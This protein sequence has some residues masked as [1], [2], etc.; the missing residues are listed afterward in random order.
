MKLR[1]NAILTASA[2]STVLLLAGCSGSSDSGGGASGDSTTI[3]GKVT[4]SGVASGKL[5][6]KLQAMA[7]APKGKPGSKLYK[8]Q[9]FKS[10]SSGDGNVEGR[11]LPAREAGVALS[12]A[13]VYL[14]DA[15]HPEWLH[16]VAETT[17]DA[18]GNF[19]LSEM[20]NAA[21][22][23]GATYADGDPIPAG[24]YTLMAVEFNPV[25]LKIETVA[26]QS[27][28]EDFSGNVSGADLVAQESEAAPKVQTMFGVAKNTDGTQTWGD[29][30]VELA[31]NAAVQI[32][33]SMAMHRL[34]VESFIEITPTPPAGKW[35]I[36]PDWLSATYYLDSGA[37]WTTGSTYTITV[38]GKD[39]PNGEDN[40][41]LNVYGKPLQLSA[42]GTFT[43][44]A[45]GADTQSPT[46]QLTSPTLAQT[47]NPIELT[48]PIR[49]GANELMDVNNLLL[50]ATPSLGAKPGVIYLGK[51]SD[52]LYEYEF[53]LGEPLK[54]NTTYDLTVSGGKDLA[55]NVM[56][57]LAISFTTEAT[58]EG[59]TVI[60]ANST[61]EEIAKA[62]AQAEVK[63]VFAKWIRAMNERNL[64][65]MQNVML[66]DFKLEYD[67]AANGFERNDVNRDG[68]YDL[69]EFSDMLSEA[70]TFWDYCSTTITGSIPSE[71][72][73]VGDLADFEFKLD[74]SS[75]NTSQDCAEATPEESLF[76]QLQKVNGGWYMLRASEGID[77][78]DQ[79]IV[80][81]DVLT[82]TAPD[83]AAVLNFYDE[84]TQ[85]DV[86]HP[87]EWN[88]VS[89]AASYVMIFV[90]ARDPESGF[91]MV[92]PPTMTT[93]DI[94]PSQ[95]LESNSADVS[96]E[97]GFHREFEPRPGSE[98]YWQ[99]AALGSNSVRDVQEGRNTAL[100]RDII[101]IS[102]LRR[103]KI[104][105]EY[106]ELD[107]QVAPTGGA[108]VT[109]SEFI[110]GY[111]LGSAGQADITIITERT[112]VTQGMVRVS[113]NTYS[114]YPV[115]LTA[116]TAADGTAIM[117]GTVTVQLNQGR[118]WVEIMDEYIDW[119]TCVDEP[120][121]DALSQQEREALRKGFQILTTGGIA[122]VINVGSVTAIA[123]NG[124]SV[125][126]T[127]DGWDYYE[128]DDVVEITVSGTVDTS[129]I[130]G[131]T[132]D[133]L[134]L[135]VWNHDLQANVYRQVPVSAGSFS[136]TVK[137][138]A[139]D[140]WINLHYCDCNNGGGQGY[141]AHFG[142]KTNTGSVYVPPIGN[143]TVTGVG[144]DADNDGVDDTLVQ[145]ENWGNGGNWRAT[146]VTS[147]TVIVRGTLLFGK[148]PSGQNQARYDAGSEGGW[149]SEPL[150]VDASGNFEIAIEL[151]NGW[152]YVNINDVKGNWYN[153]NIYT[154]GG[155]PVIRPTITAINGAA[156]AGGD[157]ETAQCDVTISGTALE[158]EV[159]LFWNGNAEDT[160][161]GYQ[162]FWEEILTEAT[163][164]DANGNYTFSATLPVV[165][166]SSYSYA[167][168]FIDVFDAN[169]NWTGVRVTVAAGTD[170]AYI[171][172]VME[173]TD[174]Q[175]AGATSL[176]LQNSWGDG[177]EYT[178]ALDDY[179]NIATDSVTIL[180]TTTQPGRTIKAEVHT[181]GVRVPYSI[182]AST[183]A[184][185]SG[186]YDWSLSGVLVYEGHNNISVSDGKNWY[187]VNLNATNANVLPTPPIAIT[188]VT[189]Y[190]GVDGTGGAIAVTDNTPANS[191]G[192]MDLAAGSAQ[193]I[194]IEGTTTAPD[195][196]GEYHMDGFGGRYQITGGAF[197]MTVNL[198]DGYNGVGINDTEWNNFHINVFTT[199]GVIRPQYLDITSH[200][201]GQTGLSGAVTISGSIDSDAD[202][203][204][205]TTDFEPNYVGA[206]VNDCDPTTGEC[207]WVEYSS[208][209]GAS[210]WGAQP[211]TLTDN[212]NGTYSFSFDATLSGG[213]AEVNVWTDGNMA[214]GAWASHGENITL[215]D[216]GCPDCTWYWKAGKQAQSSEIS[217]ELHDRIRT[218]RARMK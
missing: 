50:K 31:S 112:G 191:C 132:I 44:S 200:T 161:N 217:A 52:N 144:L 45:T 97:F 53:V 139:G 38:H 39:S 153:V 164:P 141:E 142:V 78:R 91:A 198:Y 140:N 47:A 74:G 113:G 170:C 80:A 100:P 146:A 107:T 106:L 59:V 195:G 30:A 63:D 90:D 137:V 94:P 204:T 40:A 89:D 122:P 67:V 3:S 147:N 2:L 87:F 101:A 165:G 73:I 70:F 57:S 212:G 145:K 16:P 36:S 193:S 126:L 79:T 29:A 24:N 155:K 102:E 12:N 186:T 185:G 206:F 148:D 95:E 136:T 210:E 42:V 9:Q 130:G 118:N 159:R 202:A 181:C 34:S 20:A 66:G 84:T 82:L 192:F 56:N 203:G 10:I 131:I 60:D 14:Y 123:S 105:G 4:L 15:D 129:N 171:A 194:V 11:V 43:I 71:I 32:N 211:M 28:V 215:N 68:A 108:P 92:I 65:Q 124:S 125:A 27:I 22:N 23:P 75:T 188:G 138:Y 13:W 167:D 18:Q 85:T 135:N 6:N 162:Y 160:T 72:N 121:C 98:L 201:H 143:V 199:N 196:E 61:A 1:S 41:V 128:G 8:S 205:S 62:E 99:V 134:D 218:V 189:G 48:T 177:G 25:T 127:N 64:A 158:G 154:D 214:S 49:I 207:T 114:E 172:P 133:N 175:D 166:G 216:T 96:N 116:G 76:A 21:D 35:A 173:V 209:P 51:N 179:S 180:G 88:A 46:A 157:Y 152:N 151:F 77:T 86:A 115:T 197:T 81:A 119:S 69:E 213:R 104:A 176:H 169:W 150:I 178:V 55:G 109:F 183:T 37:T 149:K 117:Q 156:Y 19:A 174:V 93:V 182:A 26:L 7:M 17:T 103:F 83:D 58:T 33:F 110:Y 190:A 163:G 5:Q 120:S 111:D 184:N 208:D 187:N 168:N 54:L